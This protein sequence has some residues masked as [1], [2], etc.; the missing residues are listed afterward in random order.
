MSDEAVLEAHG[1]QRT[2]A[3]PHEEMA[4]LAGWLSKGADLM[5]HRVANRWL[6]KKTVRA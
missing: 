6:R 3:V 2:L 4:G 5:P 1:I